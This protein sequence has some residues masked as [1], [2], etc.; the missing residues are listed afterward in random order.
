MPTTE[1]IKKLHEIL[2][3]IEQ[4]KNKFKSESEA[5]Q[6]TIS[7]LESKLLN[8]SKK[9][10]KKDEKIKF[11]TLLLKE[12]EKQFELLLT[13]TNHD[14]EKIIQDQAWK[15]KELTQLI[16]VQQKDLTSK[17]EREKSELVSKISELQ[18]KSSQEFDNQAY[19]Y[20]LK[21]SE[22]IQ[23]IESLKT[24]NSKLVNEL[25]KY[26]NSV[27]VTQD[28]LVALS[29]LS[30]KIKAEVNQLKNIMELVAKNQE[31]TLAMILVSSQSEI[32]ENQSF[33]S[34][35]PT[36]EQVLSSLN[37]IRNYISD[38]YAEKYGDT[39]RLQ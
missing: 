18:E 29:S 28:S 39:C 16:K 3:K 17:W 30:Q 15:I 25:S 13:N 7:E 11:I 35:I 31:M 37:S 5:S 34:I 32:K 21:I 38:I 20:D 36:F 9:L 14:L 12:T 23:S 27:C 19:V 22:Q 10:K 6:I 26:N 1:E 33:Y 24:H 4:E 8:S 2:S